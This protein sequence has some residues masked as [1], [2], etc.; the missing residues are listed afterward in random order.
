MEEILILKNGQFYTSDDKQ[1]WVDAVAI[2]GGKIIFAGSGEEAEKKSDPNSRIVDLG[3][4]TV[5]PGLIDAHTHLGLSVMLGGDEGDMQIWNC[6][7]KEEVLSNLK[8]HVKKHPLKLFYSAFFG[9]AEALG[10]EGLKKE[11]IDKIVKHRPVIL[12]E[13]EC[14]SA[15]LNTAALKY[16]KISEDTED[17]APGYSYCERDENGRLTGCIK[18]MTMLPLLQIA[19]S[20]SQKKMRDGM[21]KIMDYLLERGVTTVYDAGNYIKEEQTYKI[22]SDLDKQGK[23]PVRIEATHIIDLPD[24]LDGAIGEFKRLKSRY[25]TK[26]I[27]FKT[28][29]MMLDGTL[30]AHTAKMITPYCDTGTTGGTLIDFKRLYEFIKQLNKEKIDFHLHT[31]GEGAS[32]MVMD[33]AERIIREDGKLDINITLAHLE[34]LTDEDLARFKP[35]GITANFTPHWFGGI[36]YGDIEI[37][38]RILGEKRAHSIMRAKSMADS[39]ALVTFSS[40]EVSLKLLDRWSPF[41]GMET[42]MTRQEVKKGGKAAEIFPPETER[43][44]LEELIKGYTI[45]SAR[46]LRLEDKI[47]SIEE[48]KY[49]D[50]VILG[51]N[52]F[53]IDPYEIHNIVPDAVIVEG[54][55]VKGKL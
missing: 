14:H 51:D 34:S 45:N 35:L 44:S 5:L 52:I 49:A 41:L 12:M 40:D 7:S 31:V 18:E 6:R 20:V 22:L 23:L 1:P 3:G 4:R 17:I 36:D 16:I 24:K 2:K 38:E 46:V 8:N 19:G 9:M 10:Q 29:K 42:G 50:L 37:M 32:K 26:N 55:V 28:M 11:E 21:L 30:R 43:L 13:Q 48:G 33:C 39:G 15:W 54:E 47:G 53:Q 27:K 25:E